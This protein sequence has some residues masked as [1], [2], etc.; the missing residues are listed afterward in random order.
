LVNNREEIKLDTTMW[1]RISFGVIIL[2]LIMPFGL[3]YIYFNKFL[4]LEITAQGQL[5][6]VSEWLSGIITPFIALASYILLYRTY[7]SQKEELRLTRKT[8]DQQKFETTFFNMLN[9]FDNYAKN[10]RYKILSVD[11]IK[12]YSGQD[13]FNHMHFKIFESLCKNKTNKDLNLMLN[14]GQ[15]IGSYIDVLQCILKLIDVTH[16]I[17]KATFIQI[18]KATMSAEAKYTVY[19]YV[20]NT[21]IDEKNILLELITKYDICNRV[22]NAENSKKFNEKMKTIKKNIQE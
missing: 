4:L 18:L 3:Q 1:E 2:G 10:V 9:L 11:G 16:E 12:E 14:L 5:G 21:C 20:S 6:P 13:Y 7:Y 17:N 8:M 15:H 22:K 19:Y